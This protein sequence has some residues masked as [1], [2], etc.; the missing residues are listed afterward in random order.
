MNVLLGSTLIV[1]GLVFSHQI[2]ELFGLL[3]VW[4]LGGFL[5]YA[6]IRH[7]LLILDLRGTRLALALAAGLLGVV[8]GN[9]A[10]TTGF[11]L[12]SEHGPRLLRSRREVVKQGP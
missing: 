6:G 5:A 1:S 12:V 8:T 3:P 11:A 4:A 9:L 7:A 2:L 10:Y